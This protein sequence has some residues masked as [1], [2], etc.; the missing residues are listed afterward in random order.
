MALEAVDRHAAG[1]LANQDAL[2]FVQGTGE[3]LS[4]SYGE[5]AAS[6]NRFA[7]VLQSLGVAKGDR[8]F[9][10]IGRTPELYTA[11][12]GT[13]KNGSVFCPLFS[14]FGPE[15]VKQRLLLG[16]GKVLVT[17][18][19]LYRKKIVPIRDA[20]PELRHVLLTDCEGTPDPGTED[21]T[22]LMRE[23]SADFTLRP[24]Q[25]GDMA[26]LHFTSGTTGT[27]KGAVHVHDAVTAH[28][29]TGQY[30]L[31]FHPGDIYWCTADPG[32]VTGTS[33]GIISPLAHGLTTVVDQEEMDIDRWYRYCR[34][35]R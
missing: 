9:S 20:L 27:P 22:V 7:N 12:A 6:S 2:R 32:W 21:L 4:V 17:T 29:M 25:A 26:L 19:A 34:M 10:L 18:R 8:V 1:P 14:A 5:L 15:P 13:L 33:Y 28:Y 23:A 3:V 30:A 31:D 35:N 16:E 11:V 24:T